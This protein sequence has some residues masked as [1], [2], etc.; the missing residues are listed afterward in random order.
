MQQASHDSRP[1]R[2]VVVAVDASLNYGRGILGG[3]AA[4]SHAAGN[5]RLLPRTRGPV[6]KDDIRRADDYDGLIAGVAGDDGL[7]ELKNRTIPR[8]CVS[9]NR[10]LS[11]IPTVHVDNEQ[12]GRLAAEHL[13][14]RG[15]TQFAGLWLG[16]H[17]GMAARYNTFAETVRQAGHTCTSLSSRINASR[18]REWLSRQSSPLGVFAGSDG[19]AEEIAEEAWEMGWQ[20]PEDI[21]IVGVDNDSVACEFGHVTL[22]SVALPLYAIGYEAARLLDEWMDAGTGTPP[23]AGV[24]TALDPVGLIVRQSSD[25]WIAGDPLV[26]EVLV[27]IRENLSRSFSIEE[28]AHA[29]GLGRRQVERRFK[30]ETGNTLGAVMTRLRVDRARELLARREP[31]IAE[32]G[33]MCGYASPSYFALVFRRETGRTPAEYRAAMTSYS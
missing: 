19:L 8:V 10:Q 2:H 16:A 3:I 14:E 20:I 28:I 17:D 22:S 32:V 30:I 24:H 23:D 7:A 25:V 9:D 6:T 26:A 29:V 33:E 15:L 13:L 5:W 11:G 12:V 31:T 21:A 1:I 18:M 27:Y 4:Y